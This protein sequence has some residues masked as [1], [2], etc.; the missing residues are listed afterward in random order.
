[1][2]LI[3]S[4]FLFALLHAVG[5]KIAGFEL[6]LIYVPS[7]LLASAVMYRLVEKPL[8]DLGRKVSTRI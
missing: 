8:M 2:Y 7:V 4:T 5:K 3:H 6:L 1:M